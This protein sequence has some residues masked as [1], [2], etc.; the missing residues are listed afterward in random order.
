MSGI[1]LSLPIK[2]R[3]LIYYN[4]NRIYHHFFIQLVFVVFWLPCPFIHIHT[5]TNGFYRLF[6]RDY[7]LETLNCLQK[8]SSSSRVSTEYETTS[9][10][11]SYTTISSNPLEGLGTDGTFLFLPVVTK[12]R[13][14]FVPTIL[15]SYTSCRRQSGVSV[16]SASKAVN[17]GWGSDTRGQWSETSS[18]E[19]VLWLTRES[20]IQQFVHV[21]GPWHSPRST[22]KVLLYFSH[23]GSLPL[24]V[25]LCTLMY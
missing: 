25:Y 24:S 23:V 15:F 10:N 8:V 9:D 13:V 11:L 19:L 22:N 6:T 17:F 21:Y 20:S 2:D 3:V 1:Y 18:V 4:E 7:R 14:P 16:Y 5:H 12:F